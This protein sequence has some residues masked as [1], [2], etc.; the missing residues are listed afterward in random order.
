MKLKKIAIGLNAL[1]L[2]L[3]IGYFVGH[4]IP[5]SLMLWLSAILWFVAPV[6]NLLYILKNKK[7]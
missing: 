5:Q 1:L 7:D 6:V 2:F 4:G 3:C